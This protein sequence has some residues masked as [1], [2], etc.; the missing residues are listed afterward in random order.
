MGY[1]TSS[2]RHF[3]HQSI[4]VKPM[5][6]REMEQ[7]IIQQTKE[8]VGNKENKFSLVIDEL[9]SYRGTAG[10]EVAIVLRNLINR[11]GLI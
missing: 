7:P 8:A 3:N 11:L 1:D 10:T 2:T 9:H 6:L 4:N 5:L